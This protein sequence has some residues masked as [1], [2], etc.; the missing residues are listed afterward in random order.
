MRGSL[1]RF[2][3]Q[4]NVTLF[5]HC[6][7]QNRKYVSQNTEDSLEHMLEKITCNTHSDLSSRLS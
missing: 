7:Y 4:I 2:L 6:G 3:L 1:K 5:E